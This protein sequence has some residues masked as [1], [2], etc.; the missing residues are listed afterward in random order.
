MTELHDAIEKGNIEDVRSLINSN[1]SLINKV[2]CNHWLPLHTAAEKGYLEIAKLLINNGADVNAE[3]TAHVTLN[4]RNTFPSYNWTPLHIA[5]EEGNLAMVR[6]LIEKGANTD[7]MDGSLQTPLHIAAKRGN[8]EIVTELVTRNTAVNSQDYFGRT[9]LW[10]AIYH[11]KNHVIGLPT[12]ITEEIS[13]K[14]AKELIV[15][16]DANPNLYNNIEHHSLSFSYTPIHL[17]CRYGLLEI[18]KTLIEEANC[19]VNLKSEKIESNNKKSLITPLYL[20][21]CTRTDIIKV[22]LNAGADIN[23]KNGKHQET[24]ITKTFT[25]YLEVGQYKK[26]DLKKTIELLVRAGANVG[27]DISMKDHPVRV[28]IK[29]GATTE[30]TMMARRKNIEKILKSIIRDNVSLPKESDDSEVSR[31]K[32]AC[33]KTISTIITDAQANKIGKNYLYYANTLE[34]PTILV[35]GLT[36]YQVIKSLSNIE[37]T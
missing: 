36:D 28:F 33:C 15:N 2:D 18:V 21:D 34:L 16:G 1:K 37:I 22:M 20:V 11:V 19:N 4:K 3:R 30:D 8:L 29:T 14:I 17:A 10:L 27:E 26:N 12:T 35:E 9:A 32:Y 24:V 5:T 25:E 31:L 13:N 7:P 6:M 23:A